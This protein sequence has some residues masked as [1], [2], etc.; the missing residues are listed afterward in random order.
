[1][2]LQECV[3]LYSSQYLTL[4]IAESKGSGEVKSANLERSAKYLQNVQGRLCTSLSFHPSF[5]VYGCMHAYI[6]P[7][8]W[9]MLT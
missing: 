7:F 2:T 3:R 1:M 5:P 6:R 4:E 8:V 9:Q